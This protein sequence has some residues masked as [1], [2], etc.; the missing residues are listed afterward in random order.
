MQETVAEM[1]HHSD[2]NK[3]ELLFFFRTPSWVST[4][5]E[6]LFL[7]KNTYSITQNGN[8]HF[9]L[10]TLLNCK[11]DFVDFV[12]NSVLLTSLLPAL[13][14]CSDIHIASFTFSWSNKSNWSSCC[15]VLSHNTTTRAARKRAALKPQGW[16]RMWTLM[17]SLFDG[18]TLDPHNDSF[19]DPPSTPNL[20]KTL[21]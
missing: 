17:T 5:T 8:C 7:S 9:S 21:P 19:Q 2:P 18:S 11:P 12:G 10:A 6:W 1:T 16:S 15:P 14:S 4:R 3:R 20:F 13:A